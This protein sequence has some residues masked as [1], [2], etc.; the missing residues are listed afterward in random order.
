M[1]VLP[2]NDINPKSREKPI[3]L[4]VF[5]ISAVKISLGSAGL[6][7]I[8]PSSLSISVRAEKT[9]FA[10]TVVR[11]P[12]LNLRTSQLENERREIPPKET[13]KTEKGRQ[14]ERN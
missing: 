9:G 14:K 4:S 2:T 13:R 1:K 12:N 6:N 7:P 8:S 3:K 11:L 5:Y 10:D